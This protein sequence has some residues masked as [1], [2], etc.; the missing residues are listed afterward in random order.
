MTTI[1]RTSD[2][3]YFKRCRVLWDFTSKIRQNYEPEQRVVALDFGT[4]FHKSMEALYDPKTW[5]DQDLREANAVE[6][7]LFALSEVEHV[8]SVSGQ[9]YEIEFPELRK[10]G[11]GM[12][13]NYFLYSRRH[14]N[15]KPVATEIEFE[16]P[17]PGFEDCLVYQGR[18]DL[19]VEDENGYWI[20]DHKTAAQFQNTQWL[21]HDDQCASYVWALW[22][23]LGLAVRGVVYNEIRKKAPLPPTRLVRG[24]FS[25]N[26]QQDTSFEVY[27]TTLREHGINPN[28]YRTFLK[29][30]KH[31]PKEWIRRTLVRY[32][33]Q[34]MVFIEQRIM[35]EA[36]EMAFNPTIYPTPSA[37]NCNGCR[38]FAPCT[39]LL[40]GQDPGVILN[41]NY[42][43]RGTNG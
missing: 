16:V 40:D 13:R 36:S 37:W 5:S 43:K 25:Q 6:V 39:A 4:M 2:R 21:W 3:G 22:R 9:D 20:W 11:L 41:E 26:K 38:F 1:I 29:Y 14:D 30:L 19:L 18:I 34:Q 17:I 35:A 8:V 33:P 42:K 15:F 27:L 10:L 28:A 23:Q 24:G 31:N 12:L 7:F 32:T